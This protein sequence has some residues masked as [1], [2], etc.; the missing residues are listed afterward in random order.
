MVS[1]TAPENLILALVTTIQSINNNDEPDHL[2]P[3][4]LVFQ[5]GNREAAVLRNGVDEARA[6]WCPL[7]RC[8]LQRRQANDS[9]DAD[10]RYGC[11]ETMTSR[12]RVRLRRRPTQD[13]GRPN[14]T[15]LGL[16]AKFNWLS[17]THSLGCR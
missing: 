2:T 6:N 1:V 10:V 4:A 3:I 7:L 16:Q 13:L 15:T 12:C 17:E 9:P 11:H 5:L 14:P 8:S